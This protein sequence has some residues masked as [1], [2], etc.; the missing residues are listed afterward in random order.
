MK[1]IVVLF[2][3]MI[4]ISGC[5]GLSDLWIIYRFKPHHSLDLD[6]KSGKELYGV[7]RSSNTYMEYGLQKPYDIYWRDHLLWNSL[8][9]DKEGRIQLN[10]FNDKVRVS[11]YFYTRLEDMDPL[12]DGTILFLTVCYLEDIYSVYNGEKE[13]VTVWLYRYTLE[14]LQRYNWN[15]PFPDES[16]TIKIA[17]YEY[18]PIESVD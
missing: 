6:N 15:V 18:W 17:T 14:D 12:D 13:S 9:K 7:F 1:K 10:I 11:N 3:L 4:I 16:G 5:E 8:Y 2:W